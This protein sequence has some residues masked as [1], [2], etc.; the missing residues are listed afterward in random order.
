M[1][2]QKAHVGRAEVSRRACPV[3][4][5]RRLRQG[6]LAAKAG[7]VRSSF[8]FRDAAMAIGYSPE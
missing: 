2:G 1:T 4:L 7:E 5:S 6:S 8:I 3:A